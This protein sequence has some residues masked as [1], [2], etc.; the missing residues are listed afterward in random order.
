[1]KSKIM[2]L[3]AIGSLILAILA[4]NINVSLTPSSQSQSAIA[5]IVAQTMRAYESASSTRI[6]V[7]N[8]PTSFI[9]PSPSA[10]PM[11]VIKAITYCRTGPG[12][13]YESIADVK[14]NQEAAVIGKDSAEDYWLIV[15]P[16]G[17]CWVAAQYI[18]ITGNIQNIPEVTP[19]PSTPSGL[20][21]R[22]GSLYYQY[23]CNNSGNVST[24]LTWVDASSDEAGFHV[25]RNG[26]LVATLPANSTSYT[27]T[28]SFTI[29]S[30]II[31]SVTAYNII[32][33]SA[34][35]TQSFKCQ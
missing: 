31:Y 25:Y 30:T 21:A 20:P 4:C 22:P 26:V 12:E 34:P 10:T 19:P 29:G 16:S 27:D 1:M 33:E 28:T 3:A 7:L 13:N 6:A 9:T 24:Q 5:T 32:G 11:A 35:R 23:S 15:S 18:A 2:L 14:P 8:T 17:D